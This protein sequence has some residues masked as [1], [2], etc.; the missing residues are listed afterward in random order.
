MRVKSFNPDLAHYE[1]LLD[2]CVVE[3]LHE[4]GAAP[5]GDGRV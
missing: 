4:M 2:D 1:S 3:H 5:F